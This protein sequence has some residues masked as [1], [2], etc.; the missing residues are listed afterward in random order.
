MCWDREWPAA[1]LIAFQL[2]EL[3]Y[4]IRAIAIIS[5]HNKM[6]F[7][8]VQPI[9]L[10]LVYCF[11][12]ANDSIVLFCLLLNC[13]IV[14]CISIVGMKY[15]FQCMTFWN[16]PNSCTIIEWVHEPVPWTEKRERDKTFKVEN[17]NNLFSVH[18]QSHQVY[19]HKQ[20]FTQKNMKARAFKKMTQQH[21]KTG[22]NEEKKTYAVY[23]RNGK[24]NWVATNS[25]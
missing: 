24:C 9:H 18:I 20:I 17:S 5:L 11:T 6:T 4:L 15:I 8:L 2:V 1:C 23:K 7:L 25:K 21:R 12:T 10:I 19:T 22:T 13:A 16:I 3:H 14:V